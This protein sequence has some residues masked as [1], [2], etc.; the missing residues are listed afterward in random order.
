MRTAKIAISLDKNLLNKLDE[1]VNR[2]IF[3]NRSQAFQEAIQERIIRIEKSRLAL[4]CSK[5]D[6]KDEQALAN[7]GIEEDMKEWPDF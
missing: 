7:E 5:L 3:K 4:E 6:P 2:H 1:L